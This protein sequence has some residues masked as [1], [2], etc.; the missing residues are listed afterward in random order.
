VAGDPDA[1]AQLLWILLD[2]AVKYTSPGGNVWVAVTQRGNL[3]QLHVSDD[4]CGIPPGDM[5]RIFQRFYQADS[6][7]SGPGAGLGL[8]IASWIVR[9][10][11]GHIIAANNARGGASFVAELPAKHEERA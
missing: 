7:R 5:Q 11:G 10:H 8:S 3:A 6:A 1:L 4:G 2:N 9:E